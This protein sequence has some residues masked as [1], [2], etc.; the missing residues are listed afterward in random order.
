MRPWRSTAVATAACAPSA[1]ERSATALLAVPP[2]LLD[3]G[4]SRLCAVRVD[5]NHEHG[6]A[7]LGQ[8]VGD[9]LADA[10]GPAGDDGHLAAQVEQLRERHAA[11]FV[12][13]CHSRFLS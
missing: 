9:A 2:A 5:V 10:L 4:G 7:G 11:G 1:V 12:H 6:C 8:P 3:G 13:W